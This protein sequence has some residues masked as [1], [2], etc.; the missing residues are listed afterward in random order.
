MIPQG[1]DTRQL[2][3]YYALAQL[4]L[5]MAA[6]VGL[7]YWLDERLG[8]FPWLT[9][10]GAIMGLVLG[11]THLLLLLRQQEDGGPTQAKGPTGLPG[12]DRPPEPKKS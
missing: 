10:T 2:G 5:E 7:G 12:E 11:F 9:V 3:W 8:W 6:P 1:P 4:G